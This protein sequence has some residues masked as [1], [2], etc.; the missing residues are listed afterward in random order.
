M[1]NLT[2]RPIYQK[3]NKPEKKPKPMR[4]VSAKRQAQRASREGSMAT[5][6]MLAVKCLPCA[7]C[8]SPAPNDAHHPIC[9]RYGTRKASDWHVISLCKQHHQHGPEAI[10]NGKESWAKK[11]GPDHGYVSQ[12]QEAIRAAY[13][14]KFDE[15]LD[16]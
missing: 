3:Q 10:H 2:G 6:Y 14:G 4:K 15:W 16:L 11:H 8:G 9:D 7:V 5:A 1:S 12:T 13:P